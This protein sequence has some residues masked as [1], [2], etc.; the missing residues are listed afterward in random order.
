MVSWVDDESVFAESA[1]PADLLPLQAFS[2]NAIA[3]AI[4]EILNAFF[5]GV[6]FLTC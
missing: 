3:T 4:K 5:I 6:F 2:D 1:L